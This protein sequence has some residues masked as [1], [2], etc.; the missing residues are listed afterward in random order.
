MARHHTKLRRLEG[1]AND[2]TMRCMLRLDVNIWL[3]SHCLELETVKV[4]TASAVL[5]DLVAFVHSTALFRG[6]HSNRTF[7][8]SLLHLEYLCRSI[9]PAVV[10][11]AN[12]SASQ[13]F[14]LMHCL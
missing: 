10:N 7:F 14:N 6:L 8:L 2:N 11:R 4:L 3:H 5:C 1:C 13:W 9:C 12:R